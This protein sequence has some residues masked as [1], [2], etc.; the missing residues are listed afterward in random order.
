MTGRDL[1]YASLRLIGAS[2]P[3]ESLDASEA[4]D[5][6]AALNALIDSWSNEGLIIHTVTAETPYTLTPSD[7]TITVGA[8]GNI[9][10]RY[11]S[12][13]SALIRDGTLD[14]PPL[15]LLTLEE[16]AA[17]PDKSTQA[18]YPLC[19]YDDGGYP[20]RTLTLWPVPSAAKALV[21]FTKRALTQIST[22]DTSISLPPG[23]ERALKYNLA[24]DLATE[25]GRT[26]SAEVATTAT[27][28]KA[29]IK[30][31]NLKPRYLSTGGIP[32]GSQGTYDINTGGFR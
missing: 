24:I 2:A 26:V 22:L 17:I 3:G 11:Q 7:G 32:A 6:L 20:Q 21:L 13:E 18:T 1:V 12:L 31:A 19:L 8:S 15:R 30:R 25:Y 29:A 23:Y 28:S 10:T 9:T 16:Y 14:L 27:E 5:G 4:T